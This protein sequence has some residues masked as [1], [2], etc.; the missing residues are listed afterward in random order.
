MFFDHLSYI[1]SNCGDAKRN[2]LES[3]AMLPD[4]A[5][6]ASP[7]PAMVDDFSV[8]LIYAIPHFSEH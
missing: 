1:V 8:V 6:S 7:A 2:A 5:A 4:K 3:Q